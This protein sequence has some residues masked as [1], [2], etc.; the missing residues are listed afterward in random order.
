LF[1]VALELFDLRFE[2]TLK[3]SL[4]D[5]WPSS[6]VL[7]PTAHFALLDSLMYH[8]PATTVAA[9]AADFLSACTAIQNVGSALLKWLFAYESNTLVGDGPLD[10]SLP[11]LDGRIGA[12][13]VADS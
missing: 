2:P 4:L 9:T 7:I 12:S 13:S 8:R 6:L 3:F 10:L 5:L 1:W 11:F